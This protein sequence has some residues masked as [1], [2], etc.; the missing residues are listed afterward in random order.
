MLEVVYTERAKG[1]D[2]ASVNGVCAG[3]E[4]TL[5]FERAAKVR[6]II[7]ARA[8]DAGRGGVVRDV[9]RGPRGGEGGKGLEVVNVGELHMTRPV[10][11]HHHAQRTCCQVCCRY[12]RPL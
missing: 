3:G 4:T 6:A 11:K 8:E 7:P 9:A 2:T 12:L 1:T 10:S 5:D